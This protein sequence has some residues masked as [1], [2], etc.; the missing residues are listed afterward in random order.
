MTTAA[1]KSRSR[2]KSLP[3]GARGRKPAEVA[4]TPLAEKGIPTSS[5]SSA[6]ASEAP[7]AKEMTGPNAPVP[8][9]LWSMPGCG[10]G[11]IFDALAPLQPER[12]LL[13]HSFE[14]GREQARIAD[15]FKRGSNDKL[16]KRALYKLLDDRPAILH[17]VSGDGDEAFNAAL[18]EIGVGAGYRHVVL[19]RRNL[20]KRLALQ[21]LE[22]HPGAL[23]AEGDEGLPLID[24][25]ALL[26]SNKRAVTQLLMVARMAT[27][28]HC[29]PVAVEDLAVQR[30][31][32]LDAEGLLTALGLSQV[33]AALRFESM[34]K[35]ADIQGEPSMDELKRFPGFEDLRRDTLWV[36]GFEEGCAFVVP[37]LEVKAFQNGLGLFRPD[38]LP[39]VVRAGTTLRLA[40]V[41]LPPEDYD[42]TGAKL[43][44][45]QGEREAISDWGRPS[46]ATVRWFPDHPQASAARFGA[47]GIRANSRAP[48]VIRLRNAK[49]EF[50]DIADLSFDA[51][52]REMM[53]GIF[54]AR[55]SIGYRP[56][57]KVASTSLRN[58]LY[59]LGTGRRYKGENGETASWRVHSYFRERHADI[60]GAQFRFVVVRDPIKRFLSGYANRVIASKE[61]SREFIGKLPIASRLDL[62]KFPYDPD[63]PTFIRQF[64]TYRQIP[65]IAHHFRPQAEFMVSAD[66]FDRIYPIEG[67]DQLS[68]DIEARCGKPLD[69]RREMTGGPKLTV[70]DLDGRDFER[71]T[72]MYEADYTM[73][74]DHYAPDKL[75]ATA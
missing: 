28:A 2:K 49:G 7:A 25:D 23:G 3:E 10:A 46:L 63:L 21:H 26:D 35:L 66:R 67:L 39:P 31:G 36:P 18:V 14:P 37:R 52:G 24:P 1:P 59:K 32:K 65:T 68:S 71:L 13:T 19:Y 30:S 41:A 51:D 40:G 44:L 43:I 72:R 38:R 56:I 8:F 12:P 70:D 22:R 48:A 75:K 73:L 58:A 69:L 34:A 60:S 5:P 62:D 53:D 6:P 9:V 27:A 57:P 74:A 33:A 50:A 29:I 61:L 11:R 16:R 4:D 55:W 20:L 64:E 54:L 15:L 45:Q 42:S 47:I 17:E